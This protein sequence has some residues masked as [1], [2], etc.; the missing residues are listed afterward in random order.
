MAKGFFALIDDMADPARRG[1]TTVRETLTMVSHHD[2]AAEGAEEEGLATVHALYDAARWEPGGEGLPGTGLYRDRATGTERYRNGKE[3]AYHRAL[4]ELRSHLRHAVRAGDRPPRLLAG[5]NEYE[6]LVHHTTLR[7]NALAMCAA[8]PAR[9]AAAAGVESPPPP[10]Y[11]HHQYHNN[12]AVEAVRQRLSASPALGR[13]TANLFFQRPRLAGMVDYAEAA[14][15]RSGGL[16]CQGGKCTQGTVA[17][18]VS[19][20]W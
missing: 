17:Q 18:P 16:Q 9:A 15:P 13:L 11:N 2:G 7:F 14:D 8:Q 12:L 4:D 19:I 5:S 3:A 6:E 1:N 20:R 10:R